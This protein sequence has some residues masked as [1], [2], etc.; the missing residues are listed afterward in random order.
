[1][2]NEGICK[3]NTRK[4]YRFRKTQFY[5]GCATADCLGCNLRCAYCWAQKK[6]WNSKK[7]G[8]YYS[9]N[10]VANTL[11]SMNLPL[12]RISGGEPTIC[13]PHLVGVISLIPKHRLFVLETNGLLLDEQYVKILSK[14]KNLYVRVSLKGVDERSFEIITGSEGINFKKQLRALELLNRYGIENR[15]AIVVDIFTDEQIRRLQIPDLEFESLMRY[16]F[17]V[18]NLKE[19]GIPIVR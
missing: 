6:V 9:P 2:I 8:S 5:G 13:K 18:K 7:D 12:V 19:R 11:I 10:E 15:A 3:G 14:F 17:V 16:P 1:M 4:Y